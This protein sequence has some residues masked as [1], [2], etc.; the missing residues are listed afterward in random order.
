MPLADARPHPGHNRLAAAAEPPNNNDP[1]SRNG[2]NTCGTNGEGSYRTYR[3][4]VRWFGDYRG[5]VADV[6]GG[7][8]CIDLR[9]WY[10]SRS[11]DYER[12]SAAGLRN[13]EGEAISATAL[14]RMSRALWRYGRSDKPSQQAAVMVYVHR[15]MGD[16][17]PGEA[18]PKALSRAEP[19]RSTRA[20]QRDAERYAGPYTVKADLPAKLISGRAA[21]GRRSRCSRR[22]GRRVPNVD[23]ALT[24][25]GA[26]GVRRR[27]APAPTGVATVPVTARDPEAGVT[28]TRDA[29]SLPADLP[30][31]YVPTQGESARNAQRIVAPATVS[32]RARGQGRR[33]GRAGSSRRRSARRPRRPARRSPTR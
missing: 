24:V 14:R 9:F 4:G 28:L 26:D 18:D 13:K 6:S 12:R 29:P 3:Y 21:G 22:S 1:C 19:G 5:A 32:P 2:R 20:S 7:T 27:S 10:P 11:F 15:L 30:A 23:V 25:T 17:A 16:G 31:L 33:A 8:F